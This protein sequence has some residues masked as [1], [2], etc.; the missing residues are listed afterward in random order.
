LVTLLRRGGRLTVARWRRL[1]GL[2]LIGRG[3]RRWT[4]RLGRRILRFL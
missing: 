4:R 2:L 3:R 1:L